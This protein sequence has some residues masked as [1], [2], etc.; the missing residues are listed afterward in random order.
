MRKINDALDLRLGNVGEILIDHVGLISLGKWIYTADALST[1][2]SRLAE[3][4]HLMAH[5]SA[6]SV[7]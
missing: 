4:K 5:M 3:S 1:S 7:N 2:V 6:D